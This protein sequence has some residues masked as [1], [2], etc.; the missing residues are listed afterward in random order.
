MGITGTWVIRFLLASLFIPIV[1]GATSEEELRLRAQRIAQETIIVDTHIDVP[2]RL[3]TRWEDIS[4]RTARGDFDY[5]RAKAGG[6]NAPF[7]AI[8]VPA[9]REN[10]NAKSVADSLIDLVEGFAKRWPDK[11]ALARTVSDI[12]AQFREGKISLPMGME[13]GAGIEGRLENVQHFYDRGVRYI[14]LA[15][16]RD[17]H[18]CDSSYD[19]TRTWRGLS[20]FGK[21][22]VSEMNRVGM[23]IDVSH[24]T[25][26][27]FSQVIELSKAPVI[28][29]HSACRHF[30]P[31]WERNMSDDMIRKMAEQGGIIMMNFGSSFLRQEILVKEEHEQLVIREHLRTN[32]LRFSDPEAQAFIAEYRKKKP[33]MYADVKDVVT[34]INHV[35]Q[36]VGIDHV[37]LGSDFD[38]L[39][40]SLPTGLKDV[41]SYPNLIYELLKA[42][43]SE[44]DIKKILSENF[45]RVWSSIDRVARQLQSQR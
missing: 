2:Y 38:G 7:M 20:P 28:A 6:L 34:H 35:V 44:P 13:N 14:T 27:A 10:Q 5:P 17:N 9:N 12:R 42:G 25:D 41:S 3:Q 37:G 16:S 15:H 26:D 39:G 22:L 29:S 43:Y 18:I 36:L 30:T 21:K 24:I 31:D 8:Y 1:L 19:T 33:V 23:M 40:D 11:F 4:T 32:R 45:F